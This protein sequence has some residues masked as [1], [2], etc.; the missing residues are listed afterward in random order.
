[1]LL[2]VTRKTDGVLADP[3][4]AV[5]IAA[6]TPNYCELRIHFWVDTERGPGLA[7]VRSRV[8]AACL[9]AL[10]DGG[11]TLSSDVSTAVSMSR[12]VVAVEDDA[13]DGGEHVTE[14]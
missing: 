10:R 7:E 2:G 13:S 1:M 4:A 11:F 12:V 14:R 6:F 9:R 5:R 8:M 3:E